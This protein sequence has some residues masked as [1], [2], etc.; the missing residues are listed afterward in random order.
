[1]A[2]I[3]FDSKRQTHYTSGSDRLMKCNGFQNKKVLDGMGNSD[4]EEELFGLPF[5]GKDARW[6]SPSR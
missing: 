6:H 5:K 4:I 3:M 1:M 2:T